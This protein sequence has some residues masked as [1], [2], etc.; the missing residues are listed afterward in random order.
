M[1]LSSSLMTPFSSDPRAAAA[2][3]QSPNSGVQALMVW[4]FHFNL[5]VPTVHSSAWQQR[6][7]DFFFTCPAG[8]G[9]LLSF[10]SRSVA[11]TV[12]GLLSISRHGVF[13]SASHFLFFRKICM[14]HATLSYKHIEKGA[15]GC[16]PQCE[17]Q[18]YATNI[19]IHIFCFQVQ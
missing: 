8:F 7:L 1:A 4:S 14:H 11:C 16:M 3:R 12:L 10:F 18:F 5:Q 17:G 2:T 13:S 6:R 15:F 19:F 9:L